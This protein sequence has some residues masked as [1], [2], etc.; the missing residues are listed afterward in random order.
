[1]RHLVVL[2][3]CI[4]LASASGCEGTKGDPG[5]QGDPGPGGESLPGPRG[6]PGPKGDPGEMG[7]PGNFARIR[8]VP[9]GDN[10]LL[11]GENLRIALQS[12]TKVSAEEPWLLFLEPGV[13]DLGSQ[14]L[15]LRPYIHLQGSGQQLSTVRSHASGPTLV[16]ADHTELRSLTVEH[17]G[18][19][20]EVVALSNASPL[21][22]ARDVVFSARD[23]S[24]RTVALV[25]SAGPGPGGFERVQAS[26][27]SPQGDTVG[28]SCEGCS[29]KVSGSTFLAQG[30][31]RAVSVAVRDGTVELWDSS[32]TGQ[33][34]RSEAVGVQAEASRLALVR[35][36]VFG[37]EGGLSLGVRL[38]STPATV[39]D[40]T[41]SGSGN[42]GQQARALEVLRSDS[43][44]L[45]VDVQRSTL[46]GSS[47]TVRAAEGYSIRISGSQLRGGQVDGNG[48]VSCTGSYDENFHSPASPACP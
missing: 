6:E 1:M 5:P 41:L 7:P 18:G 19:P 34:G 29:V 25:S 24:Q 43:G 46:V 38:A 30:G 44:P 36:E 39:R 40:S 9:P 23:G 13:Y 3:V 15:Q 45:L 20:G 4:L 16:T 28:F 26:A 11:G 14:G 21:F 33:G 37:V 17:V 31:E 47:Q 32:A 8:V 48:I 35:A 22:R 27:S 12:I 2:P 42:P 10:P